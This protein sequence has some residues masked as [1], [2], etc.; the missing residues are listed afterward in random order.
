[1]ATMAE[2]VNHEERGEAQELMAGLR[3]RDTDLLDRLIEQY[4]LRLFRYLLFL[5][6]RRDIAEDLFQ[7]TW[8]RVLEKGHQFNGKCKF[9]P[10]LFSIAHNLFV[11]LARR[12][13][14]AMSL[15]EFSHAEDSRDAGLPNGR[16]V[17]PIERMMSDE[18]DESVLTALTRLPAGFR[19]A[20]VLRFYEGLSLEEIGGVISAPLST[21]KSRIYRGLELLRE[22]LE[23]AAG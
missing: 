4:Q 17:A 12:K 18:R 9:E 21:V 13:K 16:C 3:R 7:E 22:G 19:E 8:M 2:T 23:G 14:S 10:W 1:M 6:G 11:D 20:L 15:D 5:S